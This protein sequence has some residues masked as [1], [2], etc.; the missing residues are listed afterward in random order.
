M[1]AVEKATFAAGCFWGVEAAFAE[2]A[3]VVSTQVGY[4]GGT[5]D[6]PT[7]EQVCTGRTGHAEAVEVVFDPVQISYDHLL[8]RFWSIH[9]PTTK[10]RQGPD[11]GSQYRSAIFTHSEDQYHKA[12]ASR[13]RMNASGRYRR[14]IVTQIQPAKTFWPAEE[15]HQQYFRRHGRHCGSI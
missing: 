9:D 3:G 15:Y 14:P 2:I 8:I 1:A 13:D 11:V 5:V 6:N 10:D 12:Q 4:T 7:Y